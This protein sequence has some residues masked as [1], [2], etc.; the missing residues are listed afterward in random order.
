MK[1]KFLIGLAPMVVVAAFLAVPA[2]SQAAPHVY[3]NG[4][5]QPE[6]KKLRTLQWGVFHL[7]NATTG[8]VECHAAFEGFLENP[9][10]GGQATGQVQAFSPYECANAACIAMGGKFV[11]LTTEHLSWNVEITEP[12]PAVFRHKMG[13]KGEKGGKGSVEFF[14]NCE[15]AIKEHVF[16]ETAPRVLNNGISIGSIPAEIEFDAGSGELESA[17]G[18]FKPEGKLKQQGFG[19]QELIEVKNP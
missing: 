19:A 16:G 7:T 1:K 11:E 5:I 10:G 4:V 18:G 2:A 9:T 17:V 14:Y 3:K 15:G 8:S 12:S 6:G 13:V